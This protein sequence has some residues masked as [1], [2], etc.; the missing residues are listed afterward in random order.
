M[1][2]VKLE[3]RDCLSW[4]SIYLQLP[5]T[6]SRHYRSKGREMIEAQENQLTYP[7]K[8]EP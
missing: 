8:I 5:S 1:A 4:Q 6:I 7:N 2:I 3:F